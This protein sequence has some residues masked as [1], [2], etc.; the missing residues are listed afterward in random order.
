[1]ICTIYKFIDN[2]IKEFI[3]AQKMDSAFIY[4]TITHMA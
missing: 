4:G 3:F 2:F 1:M